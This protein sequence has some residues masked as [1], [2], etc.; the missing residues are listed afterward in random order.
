MGF[1]SP[2]LKDFQI[3]RLNRQMK[4]STCKILINNIEK[5]FGFLCFIPQSKIKILITDNNTLNITDINYKKDLIIILNNEKK[6]IKTNIP[7]ATYMNENNEIMIL[8]IKN[9]DNLGKF[10]FLEFDENIDKNDPNK[11]Y[12]KKEIYYLM[13]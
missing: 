6:E 2:K 11:V 10:N 9:E 8:E 1:G 12:Q 5:G 3:R 13:N 4:E 7:R